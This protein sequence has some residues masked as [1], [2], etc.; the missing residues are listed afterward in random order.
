MAASHAVGWERRK[1]SA[2]VI[3]DEIFEN[4]NSM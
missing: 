3:N 2:F 4:L 1:H